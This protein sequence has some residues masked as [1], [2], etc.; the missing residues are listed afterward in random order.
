VKKGVRLEWQTAWVLAVSLLPV[1]GFAYVWN[2]YAVNIPFWDD[3]F[4]VENSLLPIRESHSLAEKLRYWFGWYTQTE[5]RIVYNRLIFWL[6]YKVQ[7][8]VDYRTAMI[9]GNLSLVGLSGYFFRLIRNLQLPIRYAMPAPFLLFG[10][11]SYAN[12]FWGM[13]A[14]SNFTVVFFVVVSLSFIVRESRFAFA[15]AIFFAL[16]ATL[17][18]GSGLLVWPVALLLL[19]FQRRYAALTAWT[20]LTALTVLL[21]LQGYVRPDWA[22][23]PTRNALNPANILQNFTGFTGAV[24]DVLQPRQA[25]FTG[26]ELFGIEY[27]RSWVPLLFGAILSVFVAFRIFILCVKPTYLAFLGRWQ[28]QKT[29]ASML[30]LVGLLLFVLITALAAALSRAGG[31]LS[32]V[33][34]SKYKIYSILLTLGGYGLLLLNVGKMREWV[35]RGFLGFA[36]CWHLAGYAQYLPNVLNTRQALLADAANFT[37]N[38]S[39]RFYPAGIV[40]RLANQHTTRIGRAGFYQLP[41]IAAD[42]VTGSQRPALPVEVQYFSEYIGVG[43]NTLPPPTDWRSVR[44]LVLR[45]ESK[46]FYFPTTPRL[47]GRAQAFLGQAFS[48]GFLSRI[49]RANLP[50]GRY[51]LTLY[52]PATATCTPLDSSVTV[53]P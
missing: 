21:Y 42:A 40:T 43:E 33:V 38:G 15:L 19:F 25:T 14:L 30:S 41:R 44:L 10:L 51:R 12:Q 22:P 17:T 2:C 50:A 13:G 6:I 52:E 11:A 27:R 4:V 5:H 35:F 8:V 37:E 36:V 49:Y 47:A 46:A 23:D 53:T 32:A 18:L 9:V 29:N 7:G 26:Y 45:D 16:A 1:A 39:W 48:P 24:M 3:L 20:L 31:D 28:G 34:N